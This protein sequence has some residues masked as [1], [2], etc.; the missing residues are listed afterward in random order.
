MATATYACGM[1]RDSRLPLRPLLRLVGLG[2][3]AG[4]FLAG[5]V[6]G[7]CETLVE[8]RERWGVSNVVFGNDNFEMMAPVV[9]R[10]AG[11]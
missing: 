11:T 9:A 6:D 1:V 5:T 10:L 8:R 4:V 7:I 2:A 3:L